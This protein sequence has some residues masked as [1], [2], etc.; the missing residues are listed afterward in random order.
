MYPQQNVSHQHQAE[1]RKEK[2]A[3]LSQCAVA[4]MSES[5]TLISEPLLSAWYNDDSLK[6]TPQ[7]S[8]LAQALCEHKLYSPLKYNLLKCIRTNAV[9][10][11]V[12]C[13]NVR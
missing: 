11:N 13:F 3:L 10:N 12:H 6:Y 1:M 8:V 9:S 2:E 7:P 5:Y 4:D